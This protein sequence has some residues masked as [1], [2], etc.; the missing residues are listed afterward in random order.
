MPAV[1]GG[2]AQQV[3]ESAEQTG[4]G[5]QHT[6]QQRRDTGEAEVV[7]LPSRTDGMHNMGP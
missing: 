2:T 3:A 6:A 5:M 4:Q 7:S 1:A